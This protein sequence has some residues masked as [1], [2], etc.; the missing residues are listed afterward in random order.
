MGEEGERIKNIYIAKDF[1]IGNVAV[2]FSWVTQAVPACSD[3]L[4][5]GAHSHGF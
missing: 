5:P 3:A 4:L 2:G 1:L